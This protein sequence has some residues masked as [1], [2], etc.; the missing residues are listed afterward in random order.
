MLS[1]GLGEEKGTALNCLPQIK[2]SL[3]HWDTSF[4]LWRSTLTFH[5]EM[6]VNPSLQI[7]RE[8]WFLGLW[9]HFSL[10]SCLSVHT[11]CSC[12]CTHTTA[13]SHC[14]QPHASISYCTFV[15]DMAD[16]IDFFFSPSSKWFLDVHYPS[17]WIEQTLCDHV[18]AVLKT[19]KQTLSYQDAALTW[20]STC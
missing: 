15:R 5:Q 8:Q 16:V 18:N 11:S 14:S 1:L 20:K 9:D 4:Q 7:T 10:W 12:P 3:V 2:Q 17:S 19:K 13:L 6:L